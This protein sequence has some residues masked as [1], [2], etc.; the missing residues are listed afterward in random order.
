[1]QRWSCCPGRPR[2]LVVP[3][4]IFTT[5]EIGHAGLTEAEA[6][7]KFG[8]VR[9]STFEAGSVDWFRLARQPEGFG[10]VICDAATGRLLGAHFFCA[11][12]STLAGEAALAIQSRLTARQVADCIHPYPTPSE[13]FRWACASAAG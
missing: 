9:V 11:Q 4:A 8:R 10:K 6:K 7:A 3:W 5:P 2:E 13:L 12:G 1:M